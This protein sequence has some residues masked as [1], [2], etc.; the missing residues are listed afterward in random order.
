[1][2]E[3][4]D[5]V[6]AARVGGVAGRQVDDHLLAASA[7]RRTG[8]GDRL[9]RS[10]FPDPGGIPRRRVPAV[11]PEVVEVAIDAGKTGG[12]GCRGGDESN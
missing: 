12:Q 10:L 8:H 5:R 7:D 4:E 2:Q 11:E 3:I 1:M 6:A 9:H